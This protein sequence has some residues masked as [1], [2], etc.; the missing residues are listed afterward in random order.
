MAGNFLWCRNNNQVKIFSIVNGELTTLYSSIFDRSTTVIARTDY[1]H[2]R[3]YILSKNYD[4]KVINILT[5][6]DLVV[7]DKIKLLTFPFD[8]KVKDV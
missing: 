1:K 4:I 5:G 8:T 2:R 3:L 7:F 6:V